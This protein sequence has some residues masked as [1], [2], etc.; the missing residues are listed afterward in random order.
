MESSPVILTANFVC[1][2]EVV[3]DTILPWH[4]PLR[5]A[6]EVQPGLTV[7]PKPGPYTPTTQKYQDLP[8]RTAGPAIAIQDLK[9]PERVF[10]DLNDDL[11]ALSLLELIIVFRSPPSVNQ[12][13]RVVR[14]SPKVV[15]I[16]LAR[17]L[18]HLPSVPST[19]DR[20]SAIL[21]PKEFVDRILEMRSMAASHARLASWCLNFRD[22]C[23]IQDVAYASHHWAYHVCRSEPCSDV[24]TALRGLAFPLPAV[25]FQQ[26]LDV[27]DWLKTQ[28][29]DSNG[30]GDLIGEFEAL[31]RSHSAMSDYFGGTE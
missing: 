9:G 15:Q 29:H 17:I 24:K 13:S 4:R 31:L 21:L 19:T 12:L 14:M 8:L 2:V 1:R 20:S 26:L 3:A 10:R 16:A 23:D 6:V 11:L 27:S 18:E 22:M 25:S 5:V 30:M 28:V 7:G